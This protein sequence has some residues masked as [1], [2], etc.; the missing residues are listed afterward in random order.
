MS[1]IVLLPQLFM[2]GAVVI[3]FAG[4]RI[5]S[6]ADHAAPRRRGVP[7]RPRAASHP[8][9]WLAAGLVVAALI[10]EILVG[11]ALGT[12]F[13]GGFRQDRF[14]LFCDLVLTVAALVGLAGADWDSAGREWGTIPLT[15]LAAMIA[16]SA[17][18][19]AV[20]WAA[21]A[22]AVGVPAALQYGW[23]PRRLG[24]GPWLWT[25][26]GIAAVGVGLAL[27][28]FAG[29]GGAGGG[30]AA[31]LTLGG[32][33][34]LALEGILVGSAWP[35]SRPGRGAEDAPRRSLQASPALAGATA[36]IVLIKVLGPAGGFPG[37]SAYLMGAAGLLLVLGGVGAAV[38][39][40]PGRAVAFLAAGQAGWLLAALSAHLQSSV[41]SGLYLLGAYLVVTAAWPP[42][43]GL[44]GEGGG[45]LAGLGGRQPARAAALGLGVM[46]LAG[47]PPLAGWFGEFTAAA[48]MVR[49]GHFWLLALGLLEFALAAA[50]A[51]R[52]LLTLY[53]APSPEGPRSVPQPSLSVMASV[54]LVLFAVA[55][56]V[57]A[58]P[59][60]GLAVQGAAALGLLR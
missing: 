53:L 9:P 57:F 29:P 39:A 45:G 36:L 25:A 11:S 32:L 17:G 5:G 40:T 60:H 7:P 52:V 47:L 20:L 28:G 55:Y 8:F 16:A 14:A 44:E 46:S 10:A 23:K 51:I 54:A 49:A 22:V 15:A 26:L 35:P 58:N 38:A 41:G 21:L 6:A 2:A 19:R 42:L 33:G 1:L 3:C 37:W 30:V 24:G 12:L 13:G 4:P 50:A 48:A 34:G 18:N 59:M 27:R 43:A 56:G 31:V